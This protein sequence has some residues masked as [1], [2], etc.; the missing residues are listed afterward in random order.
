MKLADKNKHDITTVLGKNVHTIVRKYSNKKKY[1]EYR[2][3]YEKARNLENIP[4]Y[5][6]QIDFELNYSCNFS[7]SMCTWSA[8]NSK[9]RGKTTWFNFEAFKE[10]IDEGV[11]KGLKAIRLNYINEPLIRKDIIDFISY[12]KKK[13]CFRYL[14]EH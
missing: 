1:D 13:R 8:E 6:I 3:L 5:P 10:I 9:G 14:S 7:C 11:P 2:E 12:A 4:K